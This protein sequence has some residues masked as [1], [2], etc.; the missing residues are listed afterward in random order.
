MVLT[1][2]AEPSLAAVPVTAPSP[3]PQA[4]GG[5]SAPGAQ[6]GQLQTQVPPLLPPEP[7]AVLPPPAPLPLPL[8]QVPPPFPLPSPQPQAHGGQGAPGAQAGHVHV[9]VPPP[10]PALP[11]S[12]GGTPPEQSHWTGGQSA[13][14]G[15]ASGCTHAQPPPDAPRA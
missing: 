11:P 7:P 12:E 2:V 13:F 4:Q 15:H 14:A 5:Q 6:A 3:H 1:V 9:H 10:P 8:P